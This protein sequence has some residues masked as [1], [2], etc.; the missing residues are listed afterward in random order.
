MKMNITNKQNDSTAK[1][2]GAT[3]FFSGAHGGIFTLALPFVITALGG[4]DKDLG[5]CFGLGMAGY[6]VS[7]LS[8]AGHLDKFNAKRTLQFS[9]A[10]ITASVVL[11]CIITGFF[12]SGVFSVNPIVLVTVLNITLSVLLAMF[13]PPMMGWVSIGHE[14]LDLSKRLAGYNVTWSLS[15]VVAPVAAGFLTEINP[16][17]AVSAAAIC[18]ATAFVLISSAHKP[19]HHK[20]AAE[21]V[22]R[23]KEIEKTIPL[24]S[25]FVYMSRIGL[26]VGCLV[27]GLARTQ[28]ALL[29]TEDLGY[30]KSQ[31]GIIT[32]V[33][34][35][36]NF[37]GFYLT[38]KIKSWHHKIAPFIASHILLAAGMTI[39]IFCGS[40]AM[41]FAAFIMIGLGQSFTYASHQYYGVSGKAKRSG[42]MAIHEM[43]ISLGY[44]AGS[45]AGGYLGECSRYWPYRMGLG[46]TAAAITIELIIY[47]HQRMRISTKY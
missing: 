25:A 22:C 17:I 39:I 30:D 7:C 28:F 29:F 45:I 11:I 19:E 15:L 23:A 2:F 37:A 44:A 8:A 1:L 32:M 31:F 34:C 10:G 33:L 20:Q 9:S 4:S 13:W 12:P 46:V 36:A 26:A 43:L 35:S 5:L 18:M 21:T 41:I 14:G 40:L 24:H 3:F 47:Q 6:L 42:S 16:S 27:I 38:G